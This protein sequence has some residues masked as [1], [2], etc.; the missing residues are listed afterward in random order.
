MSIKIEDR[1]QTMEA[2][3]NAFEYAQQTGYTRPV[4]SVDMHQLKEKEPF[5]YAPKPVV[6]P[7]NDKT[8]QKKHEVSSRRTEEFVNTAKKGNESNDAAG[9]KSPKKSLGVALVAGILLVLGIVIG[10]SVYKSTSGFINKN[11]GDYVLREFPIN[12]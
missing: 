7:E 6:D 3:L 5:S 1:Y 4:S 8:L 10:S 11:V 9:K 2:L 12:R